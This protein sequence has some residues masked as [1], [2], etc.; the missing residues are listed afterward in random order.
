MLARLGWFAGL[1]VAGV[2]VVLVVAEAIRLI[3]G[4]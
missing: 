4:A 1:W 2:L 3:L